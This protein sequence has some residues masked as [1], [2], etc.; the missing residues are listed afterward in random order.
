MTLA[1]QV[2]RGNLLAGVEVRE[3]LAITAFATLVDTRE[4]LAVAILKILVRS[5]ELTI[6]VV[7]NTG[8]DSSGVLVGR[9][10]LVD[11]AR[12]RSRL[13]DGEELP[14]R[15][16]SAARNAGARNGGRG[17]SGLQK[18]TA[19]ESESRLHPGSTRLGL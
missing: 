19:I 13:L 17:Q 8:P 2:Q 18:G 4:T 14:R 5:A 3:A 6:D 7:D 16:I 15:S 11:H 1:H 10:D 12:K 9:D